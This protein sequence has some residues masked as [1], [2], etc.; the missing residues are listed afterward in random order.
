MPRQII[1]FTDDTFQKLKDF[2]R[3]RHGEHRAMS[4]TVQE[5][6]KEYLE[7]RADDHRGHEPTN[8]IE[9]S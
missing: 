3:E 6:V 5:A 2:I 7:D 9:K 4:I 1:Y 8:R